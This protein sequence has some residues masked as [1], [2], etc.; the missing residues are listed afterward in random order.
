MF[1]G[2]CGTQIADGAAFCHACGQAQ[3]AQQPTADSYANAYAQQP[4][5]DPYAN[6]YAQ[7]PA[8]NPYA[9]AYAQQPTANPYAQQA[10]PNADTPHPGY[11][12]FGEAIQR[13]FT[14]AFDFKTRASKSEFW[15]GYLFI[16]ALNIVCWIPYIGW[17]LAL[18]LSYL[19]IPLLIRRFHDAGLAWQNVFK[20]LIPVYGIIFG[21]K[22]CLLPS[23]GDNQFGRGPAAPTYYQPY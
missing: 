5:V 11:V 3:Q 19:S 15:W 6:A 7:Q 8:A 17:L 4:A 16:S 1:C 12:N 14:K 13:V 2:H 18:P 9:N 23:V 20:L 22:S 10:V 21:V